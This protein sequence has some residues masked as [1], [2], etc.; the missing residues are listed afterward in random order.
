MLRKKS[1]LF[2]L[3]TCFLSLLIFEVVHVESKLFS[4]KKFAR[5]QIKKCRQILRGQ[6]GSAKDKHNVT[7]ICPKQLEDIPFADSSFVLAVKSVPIRNVYAPY[8]PS[9]I[10]NGDH[11]L[12]L[13]RYD[14]VLQ[15]FLNS[16]KTNI[17]CIE[18]N[19]NLEQTEKEYKTI[20]TDS[21]S[22]EDPRILKLNDKICLIYNDLDKKGFYCRTMRAAGLDVE[23]GKATDI[24]ILDPSWKRIEKNWVPFVHN[25]ELHFEYTI[26]QPRTILKLTE[27]PLEK[28]QET[29]P[30]RELKWERTWGPLRGGTPA[31]LIDGEYLAFFH[32]SFQSKL[33]QWWYVL[34]AYTFESKPPFKITKI[35]PYPILFK[36][37][38]DTALLNTAQPGKFVIFP[39]GYAVERREGNTLLHL[40]CGENDSNIKI[41]TLNKDLLLKSLEPVSE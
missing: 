40:A 5:R 3:A 13:F 9:I 24:K 8:N 34:G 30:Q 33:G 11:Y 37:I 16:F 36:G 12:L 25:D 21:D 17:G 41:I 1:T 29:F 26:S 32:S 10:E 27:T 31:R 18:L 39:G 6:L 28:L 14:T 4:T 7:F 15:M 19:R 22:S 35:S 23:N 20:A 38:Y 2:F